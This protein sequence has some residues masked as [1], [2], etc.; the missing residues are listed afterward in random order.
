MN[1]FPGLARDLH[2]VVLESHTSELVESKRLAREDDRHGR[3]LSQ[4]PV[5]FDGRL[6]AE[7]SLDASG[8]LRRN[9]GPKAYL[10]FPGKNDTLR[11]ILTT[12]APAR[13]S[14][15][16][17]QIVGAEFVEGRLPSW[18]RYCFSA[19]RGGAVM[20]RRRAIMLVGLLCL[21]VPVKALAQWGDP[22]LIAG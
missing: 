15:G 11:G 20:G 3:I 19:R 21:S 9:L 16:S 17:I 4:S 8:S 6:A 1:P 12:L 13:Q 10:F 18:Q 5:R 14:D 22:K 2:G 7:Q